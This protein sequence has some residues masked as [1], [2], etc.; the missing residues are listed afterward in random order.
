MKKF[1]QNFMNFCE[2]FGEILGINN[3]KRWRGF[4]FLMGEKYE[5]VSRKHFRNFKMKN[6]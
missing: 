1:E 3:K 5:V 4:F 2:N 6:F